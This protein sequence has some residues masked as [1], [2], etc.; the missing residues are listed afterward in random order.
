MIGSKGDVFVKIA[1]SEIFKLGVILMMFILF[2]RMF[3]SLPSRLGCFF[4]GYS[5]GH[6][7]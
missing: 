7:V 5:C 2:K 3:W 1:V 6:L 4:S